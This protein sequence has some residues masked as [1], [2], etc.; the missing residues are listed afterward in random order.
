VA[1]LDLVVIISSQTE[2]ILQSVMRFLLCCV[3][4]CFTEI[5]VT[6]FLTGL[7]SALSRSWWCL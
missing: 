1:E 3:P 5:P 2:V 6:Q 7:S 4:S